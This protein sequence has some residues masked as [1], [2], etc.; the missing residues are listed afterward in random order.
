MG[1]KRK[2]KDGSIPQAKHRYSLR[3]KSKCNQFELEN[4]CL[5]FPVLC[6]KI[7]NQLNPQSLATCKGLSKFWYDQINESR[8]YWIR[9]IQIYTQDFNQYKEDWGIF[10]TK[11]P[12]T[13]LKEFAT[14]L[15]V[16]RDLGNEQWKTYKTT[17]KRL[18][19]ESEDQWSP[20]HISAKFSLELFK[21]V[22]L[23]FK[24]IN[25]ANNNGETPLHSAAKSGHLDICKFILENLEVDKNPKDNVGFTPLHYAAILNKD[26][27]YNNLEIFKLIVQGIENANPIFGSGMQPYHCALY[28]QKVEICKFIE[29]K[30]E[31]CG[32]KIKANTFLG[33]DNDKI[34]INISY[35]KALQQNV[36]P[37]S[38]HRQEMLEK[39]LA[40]SEKSLAEN[41]KLL[42]EYCKC[43]RNCKC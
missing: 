33:S 22:A 17:L 26:T 20:L 29:E 39:R 21:E 37:L 40:E 7:L 34:K 24:N 30:W 9:K 35:Q 25:L 14:A 36:M 43:K 6:D 2:L 1:T 16:F 8:T 4:F 41:K 38:N 31:K 3:S 28:L 32:F 10:E 12:L 18:N 13:I 23:K 27:K 15:H 42:A 5:K 19:L 11:K